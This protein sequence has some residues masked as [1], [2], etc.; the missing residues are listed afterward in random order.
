MIQDIEKQLKTWAKQ[1][2]V[3]SFVDDDPIQFPRKYKDNQL[4]AEVSGIL[5]TLIS[6]GNRKQI[7]KK[8][9]ELDDMFKGHPY[10]WIMEDGF[11]HDIPSHDNRYFYRT[12]SNDK[13]RGYCTTLKGIL[14]KYRSVEEYAQ[15]MD[16]WRKL[17]DAFDFSK[18]SASK[19]IA[20][21]MRWMVRDDGIVDLGVWKNTDKRTLVIPLDTHVHKMA[22]ELGITKR[23][24]TD[25]KTVEE[26]TNYF[27]RI[28]PDDPCLGDFA[29]FGYS[30]DRKNI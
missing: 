24:T 4:N 29:L 16:G 19:R 12:I 3:P 13:M 23:K 30:I 14:E 15:G 21:F 1:Y 11:R 26:I 28:F 27:K 6:F 5:T 20:M 2:N 25:I 7:I 10:K 18:K 8:A 17:S 22:L 9:K